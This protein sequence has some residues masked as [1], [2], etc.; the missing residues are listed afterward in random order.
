MRKHKQVFVFYSRY[1]KIVPKGS[2]YSFISIPSFNFI[3]LSDIRASSVSC[4][5]ITNVCP[6]SSRKVKN[7][8]CNSFLVRVSRF[9][10]GSS[11]NT[12]RGLLTRALATETRCCSPPESWLGLWLTRS[13]RPRRVSNY[14]ARC[15]ASFFPV[16]LI[17]AGIQ[18]FSKA[19]N[20]GNK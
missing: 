16:P 14:V 12:T 10:E 19:V 6:S 18:T 15:S 4:V 8:W 11:A 20:S 17:H 1:E 5:T 2:F 9:P 7:N 3:C 13:S